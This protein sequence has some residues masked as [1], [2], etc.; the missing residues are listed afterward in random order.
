[1]IDLNHF[2]SDRNIFAY[3]IVEKQWIAVFVENMLMLL[4]LHGA[5]NIIILYI[6][7]L[8]IRIVKWQLL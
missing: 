4:Y 7:Y 3:F 1:M 8:Q 6:D 2:A 5:F